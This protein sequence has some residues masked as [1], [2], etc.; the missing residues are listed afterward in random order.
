M[1]QTASAAGSTVRVYLE[2]GRT[3]AFAVALDWPGWCRRARTPDTA[4]E[5]LD[6]YRDRFAAVVGAVVSGDV[7]DLPL[8]VVGTVAGHRTTDF[9][10]PDG[11][12]PWDTEP[13]T[14]V[15]LARQIDLLEYA[16][17]YFDQVVLP[18][19]PH[20]AGAPGAVAAIETPSCPT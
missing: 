8:E 17:V 15:E 9:G 18:L 13:L 7:P 5:A 16:W 1:A 19:R 10:A 11:R 14:E 3:S 4:L 2:V 6:V 12:G 20:C